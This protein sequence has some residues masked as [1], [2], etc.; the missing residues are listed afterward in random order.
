[1]KPADIDGDAFF[2]DYDRDEISFPQLGYHPQLVSV[3]DHV[4][5]AEECDANKITFYDEAREHGR[6]REYLTGESSFLSFYRELAVQGAYIRKGQ[7]YWQAVGED[8][9]AF[10]A[11]LTNSLREIHPNDL[12]DVYFIGPAIR[13]RGGF[14]RTDLLLLRDKAFMAELKDLAR[15]H[16][17]YLLPTDDHGSSPGN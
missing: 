10:E 6:L 4:L 17:L 11:I 8:D 16:R 7:H 9:P 15:R 5:T 13:A 3:F 14:D 1:M 2:P 12:M